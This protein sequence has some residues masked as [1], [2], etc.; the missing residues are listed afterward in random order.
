MVAELLALECG[1]LPLSVPGVSASRDLNKIAGNL[2]ESIRSLSR[3]HEPDKAVR[4]ALSLRWPMNWSRA[5]DYM[6]RLA[7]RLTHLF[8]YEDDTR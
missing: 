7:V 3:L 5:R 6:P 4:L 1:H 2:T 8:V